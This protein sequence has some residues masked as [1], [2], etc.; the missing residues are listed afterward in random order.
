MIYYN[1]ADFDNIKYADNSKAEYPGKSGFRVLLVLFAVLVIMSFF[2]I[3]S[4]SQNV[5]ADNTAQKATA[6][7]TTATVSSKVR[8]VSLRN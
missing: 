6:V 7:Q 5:H 3:S 1:T 2:E 8:L 4:H